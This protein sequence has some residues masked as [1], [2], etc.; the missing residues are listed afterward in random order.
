LGHP[1]G[2]S[3][4]SPP[5]LAINANNPQACSNP[6]SNVL[7]DDDMMR[8]ARP[9]S[10]LL[11]VVDLSNYFC[12]ATRRY[13]GEVRVSWKRP[14]SRRGRVRLQGWRSGDRRLHAER[15]GGAV[16]TLGENWKT[17]PLLP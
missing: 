15:R 9:M 13:A 8:A 7:V 4:N 12:D 17:D 10:R 3:L 11:N 1:T 16:S 2:A 14:F 5:D 6:R